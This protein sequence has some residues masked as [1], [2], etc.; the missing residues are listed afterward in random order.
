MPPQQVDG[1]LDFVGG[2]LDFGTHETL[3]YRMK[4]D[5]GVQDSDVKCRQRPGVWPSE[6]RFSSP[7]SAARRRSSSCV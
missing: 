1:L 4:A 2:A 3:D 7:N 5:I 6:N